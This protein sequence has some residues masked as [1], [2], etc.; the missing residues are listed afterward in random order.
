LH[1]SG[2]AARKGGKQ[3]G[4]QGN[5]EKDELFHTVAIP[6]VEPGSIID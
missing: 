4:Q 5:V 1:Q 3:V 6:E 2:T